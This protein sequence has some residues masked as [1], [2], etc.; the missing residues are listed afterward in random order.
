MPDRATLLA[1]RREGASYQEIGNRCGLPPGLVHLIVT[2]LPA[3]GAGALGPESP[4]STAP[5]PHKG[6]VEAW[7]RARAHRDE[8]MRRAARAR[9]PEPPPI[10]EGEGGAA[11]EDV[12]T[13]LGREHNQVTYL[14]E[15]LEAAPGGPERRAEVASLVRERLVPH[16]RAEEEVFWP[17]VRRAL[18]DGAALARAGAARAR[19][20]AGVL[21]ALDG[22]P[23][24]DDRFDGLVERL[25][26]AL[27]RHI[28]LQD[29]VFLALAEALPLEERAALGRAV[30]EAGRR[31]AGGEAAEDQAA[32]GE[33][34]GGSRGGATEG[35]AAGGKAGGRP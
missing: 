10:R 23:G 22:L 15:Q 21:A 9:T 25:A 34:A 2:G 16:G 11:S 28:A 8:P 27:R 13:V 32:G 12:I 35:E 20:T 18:P 4:P 30:L 26:L 7:L 19:E 14:V 3:D 5:P 31:A 29:R 24:G 1:M 33:A 17:A 6:S